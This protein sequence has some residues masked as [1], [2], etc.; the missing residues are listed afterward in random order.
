MNQTVLSMLR[1]LPD[2]Y[3]SSW[4]NY[5]SKV[6][7][8][9]NC[10]RN[11]ITAYSPYYVMFGRKPRLPTDLIPLTQN[12]SPPRCNHKEYLESWKKEMESAFEVALTM[13]TGRKEKDV[14]RKLDH[15]KTMPMYS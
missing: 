6:I 9:Y 5:L 12:D 7:Y 15:V 8:A 14:Q 1:T 10:T 3:K 13:F 4:K 2:K 11:S